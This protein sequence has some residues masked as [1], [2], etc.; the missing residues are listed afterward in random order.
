MMVCKREFLALKLQ[1][2]TKWGDKSC[3][4]V[5]GMITWNHSLQIRYPKLFVIADL[6]R[7]QCVSTCTCERA[8]N[9]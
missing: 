3:R 5:W 9:V 8:F 4:D 1:A 6:A 2:T 7:V